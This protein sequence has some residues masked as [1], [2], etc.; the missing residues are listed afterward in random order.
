MINGL[1]KLS[2]LLSTNMFKYQNIEEH[3]LLL[4]V[5]GVFSVSSYTHDPIN[6]R[7]II[8]NHHHDKTTTQHF[9]YKHNMLYVYVFND[10]IHYF[11][12]KLSIKFTEY[13]VL[14][15]YSKRTT[16]ILLSKG[17]NSVDFWVVQCKT[18]VDCLFI[19]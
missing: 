15:K 13:N 7:L 16:L 8:R 14:V 4:V 10:P 19:N 17:I 12:Q 2:W 11:K 9:R 6:H 5:R 1:S 18:C 3:I